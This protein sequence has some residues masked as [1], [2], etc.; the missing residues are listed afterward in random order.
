MPSSTGSSSAADLKGHPETQAIRILGVTG[1]P[2]SLRSS[3]RRAPTRFYEPLALDEIERHLGRLVD[4]PMNGRAAD[5]GNDMDIDRRDFLKLT[6]GSPHL[7]LAADGAWA[8]TAKAEVHWLGQATTKITT[9]TGKVD[10]DRPVP[11]QQSEDAAA[12]QEPRRARQGGRHLVTHGHGDH[13][14]DVAELAKRTGATVLGPAGLIAT[15]VD[16]G[17]VTPEKAVRF[18]KADA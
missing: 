4:S 16:L 7:A 5:Q 15:M 13:T 9:L 14:G 17:W 18:G 1:Y 12:I 11:D 6:A 8:Q 10:R 3:W 2:A